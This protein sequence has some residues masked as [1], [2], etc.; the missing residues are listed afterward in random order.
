M[1]HFLDRPREPLLDH[2]CSVLPALSSRSLSTASD[3]GRMKMLHRVGQQPADLRARPASRFRAARPGPPT[4]CAASQVADVAYQW[5]CTNACSRNSPAVAQ[6]LEPRLVDEVVVHALVLAGPRLARGVRDRQ[7]DAGLARQQRIDEARLAA[8]RGRG[9]DEEAPGG[10]SLTCI[11]FCQ[12]GPRGRE[13]FLN[14]RRA[15]MRRLCICARS[16]QARCPRLKI[17]HSEPGEGSAAANRDSENDDKSNESARSAT[18]SA[19]TSRTG[20]RG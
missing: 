19:P 9:D 2:P 13:T 17:G 18:S 16:P 15:L 4:T 12:H 11:L 20:A 10:G 3:G 5:P 7:A 14:K 1:P 6:R 8:A